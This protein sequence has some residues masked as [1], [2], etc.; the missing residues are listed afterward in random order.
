MLTRV[1]TKGT[2]ALAAVPGY[3]VA[4]KTGTAENPSKIDHAW[5]VG[6]APAD[7]PTIVVAV[8]VERGGQGANSAAPA[9][10]VTM[11]ASLGFAESRCGSGAKVN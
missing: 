8:V 3:S 6:Y 10:C 4:G 7:D 5:F 1:I 2:G 9:V 11:A